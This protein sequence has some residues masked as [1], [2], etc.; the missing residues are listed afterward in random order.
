M[1]AYVGIE[2]TAS[3]VTTWVLSSQG[4]TLILWC[5]FIGQ[6]LVT[7]YNMWRHCWQLNL[8]LLA[9]IHRCLCEMVIWMQ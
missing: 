6:R 1:E 7:W 8:S 2:E 4:H 9:W 5:P 3:S